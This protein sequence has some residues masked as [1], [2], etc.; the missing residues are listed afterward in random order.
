MSSDYLGYLEGPVTGF[1][2]ESNGYVEKPT[3][4][5]QLENLGELKRVDKCSRIKD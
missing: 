5:M 3:E 2:L 1:I 4:V